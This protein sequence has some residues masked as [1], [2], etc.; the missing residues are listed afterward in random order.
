MTKN[1]FK[2][3]DL[4]KLARDDIIIIQHFLNKLGYGAGSTDGVVGP[5]TRGAISR[6]QATQKL[7]V[8]GKA[9]HTLM[10]QLGEAVTVKVNPGKADE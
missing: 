6:F 3:A 7:T 10:E 4:G 1:A 9:S 5:K 8:D 2:G